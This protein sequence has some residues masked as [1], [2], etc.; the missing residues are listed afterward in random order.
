M[1]SITTALLNSTGVLDAYSRIFSTIQNNIAN[2]HTPGFAKQDQSMY[3]LSGPAGGVFAGPLVSARSHYFEQ[4]VRNAGQHLG[5]ARQYAGD[6][7]QVTTLFNATGESGIPAALN[8]FFD[9]VSQWSVNPNHTVSR[10][11]VLNA[12]SDIAA[13]FRLN[14]QG[15][16]ESS[17]NIDIQTREVL[18]SVNGAIHRIAQLNGTVRQ[19]PPGEVDPGLDAELHATLEKLAELA[20]I[21]TIRVP[22]G[23]V[24]LYL[25]GRIPLVVGDH[26]FLI[27]DDFSSAATKI[28]DAGGTD[29]TGSFG[30][31]AGALGALLTAKNTTIP[32]YLAQLNQLASGFADK[33]NATL[34]NG[35][36]RNGN[37]PAVNLFAYNPAGAAYTLQVNKL[38]PDDLA[39]ALAGAPGGNGNAI[40]LAQIASQ[41]QPNG[42]T[43]SEAYGNLAGQVG[44]DALNSKQDQTTFEDLLNQAQQQRA[45]V[46]GV[47][48]DEEAAKLIQFQQAYQA[49]A[50]FITV[51]RDLTETI[52]N[53]AR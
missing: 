40:A 41:V 6:L 10:Q 5:A 36:D 42:Y 12:A 50:Q 29:I 23:T 27:S 32:G 16:L 30:F 7:A 18:K 39:A 8:E 44:Q 22:D 15:L 2:A 17:R 43:F 14:A 37:P 45:D 3:A 48:L 52:M 21:S 34:A 9:S 33:V 26:E 38:T 20:P 31:S 19:G 28:H 1:G 51:L 49:S 46:S 47:S 35:L 11:T 4:A 13:E 25:D 53:I 24:S